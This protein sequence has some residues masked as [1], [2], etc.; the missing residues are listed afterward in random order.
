MGRFGYGYPLSAH[1]WPPQSG[2][3][4]YWGAHSLAC[5]SRVPCCPYR[6]LVGRAP[7]LPNNTSYLVLKEPD[8][9][10]EESSAADRSCVGPELAQGN[11][12]SRGSPVCFDACSI[13]HGR[14]RSWWPCGQTG[15]VA[16]C[17]SRSASDGS[18]MAEASQP[19]LWTR[20]RP[21]HEKPFLQ[22][23][24]IRPRPRAGTVRADGLCSL[25]GSPGVGAAGSRCPARGSTVVT[26]RGF[27]GVNG[28]CVNWLLGRRSMGRSATGRLSPRAA[29]FTRLNGS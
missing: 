6:R 11:P 2:F 9:P 19:P 24:P 23:L 12:V 7:Q 4:L 29:R 10:N 21:A 1:W 20:T 16:G 28:E 18:G 17:Q 26:G 15:D 14:S 5:G 13:W 22:F 3:P 27:D 25:N 8:T